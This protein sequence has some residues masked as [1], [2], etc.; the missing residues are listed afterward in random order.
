MEEDELSEARL[1]W[2][3]QRRGMLELDLVLGNFFETG[4]QDL[5]ER[6]KHTFVRLLEETDSDL[7]SW[8]SRHA[9][10]EDPEFT[11]LVEKVL[12]RVQSD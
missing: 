9:V 1:R 12:A 7:W 5:S 2:R 11:E 4:Y 10:P 6:E 8:F 3:S